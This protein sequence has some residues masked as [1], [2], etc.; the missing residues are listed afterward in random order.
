MVY[1]PFTGKLTQRYSPGFLLPAGILPLAASM[2]LF[3]LSGSYVERI[4]SMVILRIGSSF[5]HPIVVLVVSRNY[6]GPRLDSALGFESA[7]G[8]LWIALAFMSSLPLYMAL[9]W[10]GPFIIYAMLE[11]ATTIITLL[12]FLARTDGFRKSE[13]D[14]GVGVNET[15]DSAGTPKRGEMSDISWSF[16]YFS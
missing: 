14:K 12:A 6:S 5:F 4:L 13:I 7:F 9:G 3:P 11:A 10:P 2:F 1:Q 15:A 16:H 8:N